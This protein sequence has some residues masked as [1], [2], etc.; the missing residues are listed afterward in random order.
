MNW[1]SELLQRAP[2]FYFVGGVAETLR[3]LRLQISIHSKFNIFYG[4]FTKGTLSFPGI[5]K[6]QCDDHKM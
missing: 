5:A 6:P 4:V 2:F 3:C 1:L